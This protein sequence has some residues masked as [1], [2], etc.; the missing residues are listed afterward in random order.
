MLWT[1]KCNC[2]AMGNQNGKEL[3]LMAL[4][5][6]VAAC[7]VLTTGNKTDAAMVIV[8]F[9]FSCKRVS[10]FVP[11]RFNLTCVLWNLHSTFQVK[12]FRHNSHQVK[13]NSVRRCKQ[14]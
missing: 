10:A 13:L 6:T 7:D 2:C 1:W 3:R 12:K 11:L 8:V 5:F 4:A 9:C 14:H